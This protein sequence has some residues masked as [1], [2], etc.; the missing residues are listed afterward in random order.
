MKPLLTL[1]IVSTLLSPAIGWAEETAFV[2]VVGQQQ[3]AAAVERVV[4]AGLVTGYPDHTFRGWK[5][6]SR[7]ELIA[8]TSRLFPVAAPVVATAPA[9]LASDVAATHW[10]FPALTR[11]HQMGIGQQLWADGFLAGD[12]PATRFDLAYM[13]SQSCGVWSAAAVPAAGAGPFS[14]IPEGHWAGPAVRQ[15]TALGLMDGLEADHFGGD[16][17]IDRYQLAIVLDRLLARMRPAT[18]SDGAAQPAA[19]G[20]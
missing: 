1:A 20:R 15:A 7:Y 4:A 9:L 12:R 2:D 16:Q 10:A 17:P 8:S 13:A 5:P 6:V 14:D 18:S 11:L 19:P 3:A